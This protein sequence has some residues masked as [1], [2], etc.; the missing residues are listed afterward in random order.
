MTSAASS[1]VPPSTG[2]G[3]GPAT[4]P[5]TPPPGRPALHRSSTDRMLG[6]VC[7]G[8]AEYSGVD[9]LL[10]RVGAIALTLIGPGAFVYVLLWV[11]MPKGA[12]HTPGPLD[13]VIDRLHDA[14]GTLGN[15]TPRT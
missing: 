6:G 8:L 9:P 5:S 15:R 10:W 7:G 2:P 13:P 1:P 3:T 11:L 12:D 14:V 4:G